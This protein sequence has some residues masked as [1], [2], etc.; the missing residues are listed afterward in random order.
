VPDGAWLRMEA[1]DPH[2]ADL[3]SVESVLAVS[4]AILTLLWIVR[5]RRRVVIEGFV[6]YTKDDGQAVQG[7]A[8]LLIAELSR[9]RELYSRVNDE[10]STPMSVGAH[11]RGG[12]GRDTQAGAFLSVSADEVASTLNDAIATETT[13]AFAG[14]KIPVGFVLS[15]LGKLA[16]GPRIVGSLH[17]TD[18]T[19]GP[20]LT[21][22]LVGGKQAHQWRVD[23]QRESATDGA[24]L[25]PMVTELASR[26]FT[27][28]TLRSS[29]RWRAI[30]SFTEYLELY[31]ESYRTPRD[32]GAKLEGAESKLL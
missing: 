10:L 15:V 18:A 29:V 30:R 19:G 23:A 14:I 11:G 21:A 1:G 16:R 6:D 13:V 26:I 17:N 28:L 8:T 9:L 27:D 20:M 25:D 5:A 4:A 12:S 31:W 22:Q 2:L 32:R 3:W 24:F 7:L